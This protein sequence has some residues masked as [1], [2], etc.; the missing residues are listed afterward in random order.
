M[1]SLLKTAVREAEDG[2]AIEGAEAARIG[3]AAERKRRRENDQSLTAILDSEDRN[4]AAVYW[5]RTNRVDGEVRPVLMAERAAG[6]YGERQFLRLAA[7]AAGQ[8]AKGQWRE[9]AALESLQAELVARILAKT[10]GRMP[11]RG[12]LGRHAE[13][14]ENPDLAYLT[15]AAKRLIASVSEGDRS[16][17]G[18]AG[19]AAIFSADL[20]EGGEAVNL[21]DRMSAEIDSAE[22][23]T[24]PYLADGQGDF[25]TPQARGA[26]ARLSAL[27]GKREKAQQ[28]AI[29]AALRPALRAGDL[30]AAGYGATGGAVRKAAHMGRAILADPIGRLATVP[31]SAWTDADWRAA[32]A[33]ACLC[34]E[35]DREPIARPIMETAP[36]AYRRPVLDWPS[37]CD[38]IP[39]SERPGE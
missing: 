23:E 37:D 28:A 30:A 15:V 25:L 39:R 10:Q 12:S 5:T 22:G 33:V 36:P 1:N 9:P 21:S 32:E 17:A 2:T 26:A 20:S 29:S 18:L 34:V 19:E 31:V 14:H 38:P 8:A 16:A 7:K 24:D 4:G 13:G 6:T 11:K 35:D 27:T 3:A